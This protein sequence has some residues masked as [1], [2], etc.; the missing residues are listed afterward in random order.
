M[1]A[2]FNMLYL[3]WLVNTI[4]NLPDTFWTGVLERR[5]EED[6]AFRA[7]FRQREEQMEREREQWK[8]RS[9]PFVFAPIVPGPTAPPPCNV[10]VQ[11][12]IER[13]FPPSTYLPPDHPVRQNA[14]RD[15]K[16]WVANKVF[17]DFIWRDHRQ[18]IV[19]PP[20]PPEAKVKQL[21]RAYFADDSDMYPGYS[22][23]EFWLPEYIREA[24]LSSS[25]DDSLIQLLRREGAHDEAAQLIEQHRSHTVQTVAKLYMEQRPDKYPQAAPGKVWIKQRK[26]A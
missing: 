15:A 7:N 8:K 10:P 12:Y 24:E 22:P 18:V 11:I 6:E 4:A 5:R 1:N 19:I 16:A 3:C 13:T 2:K 20:A 14:V 26:V 25:D 23:P 17:D 21:K 9:I